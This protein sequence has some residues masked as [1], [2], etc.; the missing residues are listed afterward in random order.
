MMLEITNGTIGYGKKVILSDINL[1]IKKGEVVSVLGKNGAGKTTLFKSL[2]GL[3]PVLSGSVSLNGK[4]I[5]EW[6]NREYARS[7]AYIPQAKTLPFP[8]KVS[9]VILFGRAAHLSFFG[10]PGKKDR[11][12]VE[13]TLD[14]LKIND[15]RDKIYTNLSGGEQ[16]MVIIAR[17]L[18][19]EPD[20]LI[21]DEP[22]SNLDFGNQIKILHQVLQLRK[23][24]IGILMATHS[25]DHVFLCESKVVAIHRD[26]VIQAEYKNESLDDSFFSDIYDAKVKIKDL[27][28]KGYHRKVCFPVLE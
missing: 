14:R 4:D 28:G 10:H 18:A 9:D 1:S 15:L 12:I 16:Q 3:L 11:E 8:Y 13:R 2:L 22:T 6:G 24:G 23:E 21:M 27:D 26:K 20:F 7:V 19:Q 17:A 5:K 25:P